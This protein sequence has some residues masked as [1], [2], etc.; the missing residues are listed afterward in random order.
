M[1]LFNKLFGAKSK[2]LEPSVSSGMGNGIGSGMSTNSDS[3]GGDAGVSVEAVNTGVEHYSSAIEDLANMKETQAVISLKK[4]V[5]SLDKTVI[6]LSKESGFDLTKHQAKV[7]VVMDYSGSMDRR[8]DNGEVQEVLNRLITLSLRFDDNGELEVWIFSNRY[9][10]LEPMTIHNFENYVKE[11]ILRK[12]YDMGST[13]YAPVLED[14][15]NKYF[16]EDNDTS[17]IPTF[18]IFI[19]DGD[20]DSKD[21]AP[22]DRIIVNSAKY[23]IYFQFVGM[24]SSNFKYLQKL[25][26]LPG[27]PVDNTGFIKVQDFSALSDEELYTQLLS[28][29]PEWNTKKKV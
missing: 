28:G 7:A 2:G 21:K 24:G 23:N 20:N 16:V 25:D 19:T 9:H 8:Y 26:G 22:T 15:M 5:I 13:E 4:S 14:V 6:S 18:V 3:S 12:Y 29:Y 27:R 1:G 11:E 10:R 17:N